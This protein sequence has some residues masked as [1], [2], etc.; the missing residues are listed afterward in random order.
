MATPAFSSLVASKPSTAE[1]V[2][3]CSFGRKEPAA[4]ASAP[5]SVRAAKARRRS[6]ARRYLRAPLGGERAPPRWACQ[7]LTGWRRLMR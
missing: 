1:S 6:L 2:P 5:A 3:P 7:P 4:A